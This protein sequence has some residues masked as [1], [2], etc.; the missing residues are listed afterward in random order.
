MSGAGRLMGGGS[1]KA[2]RDR[3]FHWCRRPNGFS[4]LP[5]W[6]LVASRLSMPLFQVVAFANR[7][8]EIANDAANYGEPRG[9]VARFRADEFGMALGMSADD[10]ADIFVALEDPSIG[11]IAYGQIAEFCDRNPDREDETASDRQ[12]RKRLRDQIRP[13]LDSLALRGLISED[14]RATLAESIKPATVQELEELQRRLAWQ[15]LGGQ[16]ESSRHVTRDKPNVTRDMRDVTRDSRDIARSVDNY[17]LSRSSNELLGNLRAR[18]TPPPVT[19]DSRQR[20]EEKIEITTAAIVER[21]A[22][23]NVGR[24]ARVDPA[25][26][27]S[28]P[29]AGTVGDT[30]AAPAAEGDEAVTAEDWLA[31]VGVQLVRDRMGNTPAQAQLKLTEWTRKLPGGPDEMRELL[32]AVNAAADPTRPGL[33]HVMVADAIQRRQQEARGPQLPLM[34]PIPGRAGGAA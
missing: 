16:S 20:R 11:W 26:W 5:I 3:R 25:G 9:S 21:Q 32:C 14:A 18:S 28:V 24:F 12:R 6:R 34:T 7:L 8:E 1:P 19:R 27:P 10:A 29:V 23:D 17:L 2:A 30:E 4:D 15:E 13:Q 31:T 33:F 22:V